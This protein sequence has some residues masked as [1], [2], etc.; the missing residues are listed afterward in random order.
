[1]KT[2]AIQDLKIKQD[3]KLINWPLQTPIDEQVV[4]DEV[5]LKVQGPDNQII[6][7]Q[8]ILHSDQIDVAKEGNYP[9]IVEFIPD[10]V[11]FA[12]EGENGP[13][14]NAVTLHRPIEIDVLK[15]AQLPPKKPNAE[16]TTSDDKTAPAASQRGR[17][18]VQKTK[19]LVIVLIALVILLAIVGLHSCQ[20]SKQEAAQSSSRQSSINSANSSSISSLQSAQGKAQQQ[21]DT[22]KATVKQYQQDHDET[23]LKNQLEAL[24]Q[25]NATIEQ[26]NNDLR[27]KDKVMLSAMNQAIPQIEAHP[28]QSADIMN[29]LGL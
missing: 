24:K 12:D 10:Q 18:D 4:I 29:S 19:W 25:Q 3:R 8:Q 16:L 26:Q 13:A 22:L 5:A 17:K 11:R 2:I 20:R 23:E 27:M 6:T 9:A 14:I 21:L 1:M 7:G 28:S 15:N